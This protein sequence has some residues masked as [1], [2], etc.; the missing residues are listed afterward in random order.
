MKIMMLLVI[1][2]SVCSCTSKEQ[3]DTDEIWNKRVHEKEM[4][5]IK[6]CEAQGG[7]ME[8]D[9]SFPLGTRKLTCKFKQNK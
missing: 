3:Y 4:A 9:V 6:S 1:M 2:L 7:Y 8:E 5:L